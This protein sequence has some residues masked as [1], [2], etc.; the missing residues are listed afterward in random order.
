MKLSKKTIGLILAIPGTIIVLGYLFFYIIQFSGHDN[1][2]VCHDF[3]IEFN[4]EVKIQLINAEEIGV[5]IENA[6]LYPTGK[7]YSKI[8]TDKIESLL[9]KSPMIRKVESFKTPSGVVVVKITQ[10]VPKFMIAGVENLYVDN[11]KKFF[12]TTLNHAAYV[13]VVSGRVTQSFVVNELFDFVS[14]L[15]MNEFWNAQIE[16]I[17]VRDDMKLELVP[18]VGEGVILLGSLDGY[19]K[20]LSNLEKLYKYGFSKL[21][22]DKYS[23]INLQYE[24]QVVC[25]RNPNFKAQTISTKNEIAI[26]HNDSIEDRNL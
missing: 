7:K 20:K 25:K 12:P 15:E 5:M 11:D 2:L 17:Y 21:G 24:G 1:E 8:K 22:W 10:R 18:R 6:G 4:D 19:E 3:R 26:M 9:R 23:V 13:P 16:Q 14:F